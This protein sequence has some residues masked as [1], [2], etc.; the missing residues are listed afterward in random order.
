ML[1]SMIIKEIL[2][3]LFYRFSALYFH[4]MLINMNHNAG[5]TSLVL[6]APFV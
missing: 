4:H 1:V 2:L 3:P 6:Y 5:T